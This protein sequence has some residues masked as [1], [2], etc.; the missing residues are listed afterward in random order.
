ME[1]DGRRPVDWETG[2]GSAGPGCSAPDLRN[3]QKKPLI[4][5][6]AGGKQLIASTT[7]LSRSNEIPIVF[8]LKYEPKTGHDGGSCAAVHHIPKR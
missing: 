8:T 7:I 5:L 2:G 3:L 6:M 1:P 4:T